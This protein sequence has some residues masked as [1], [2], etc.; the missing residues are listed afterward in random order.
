MHLTRIKDEQQTVI[1]TLQVLR[2][3]TLIKARGDEVDEED[4]DEHQQDGHQIPHPRGDA[5]LLVLRIEPFVLDGLQLA[6]GAQQREDAVHL[7]QQLEVVRHEFILSMRDI[8][9]CQFQL[10]I[11]ELVEQPFQRQRVPHDVTPFLVVG[12]LHRLLHVVVGNGVPPPPPSFHEVVAETAA[13]DDDTLRGQVIDCSYLKRFALSVD[14]TMRKQLY[15]ALTILCV[16]VMEVG[17]HTAHQVCPPCLQVVQGILRRL[18][19]DFVGDFQLLEDEFQQVDV[20]AYRFT[21]VVKERIRPQVPSI[22]IDQGLLFCIDM[23][24]AVTDSKSRC[25]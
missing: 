14:D 6:G 22:L 21:R 25:P 8:H 7:F 11:V 12:I 20:I 2:H 13:M 1:G 16:L 15:D 4:E 18:Q 17:I 10:V 3:P 9:R 23:D 24:D 19:L 5:R